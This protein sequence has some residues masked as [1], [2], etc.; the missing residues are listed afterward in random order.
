MR[1]QTTPDG[2]GPRVILRGLPYA[3]LPHAALYLSDRAFHAL[4][5]IVRAAGSKTNCEIPDQEIGQA[6]GRGGK[7]EKTVQRALVELEQVGLIERRR[8]N[9]HRKILLLYTLAGREA[10]DSRPKVTSACVRFEARTR[11]AGRTHSSGM[12]APLSNTRDNPTGSV[13]SPGQNEDE[14]PLPPAEIKRQLLE[15]IGR[16]QKERP[17][18]GLLARTRRVAVRDSVPDAFHGTAGP[19]ESS[20]GEHRTEHK[21]HSQ[22]TG[23]K[24][25]TSD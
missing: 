14:K 13:S 11:Q 4:G 17:A 20:R 8:R 10:L 3:Q 12:T 15:M 18:G 16:A 5:A 23:E 21:Q 2:D 7:S 1:R 22:T 24:E 6:M 9:G 25:S 19:P